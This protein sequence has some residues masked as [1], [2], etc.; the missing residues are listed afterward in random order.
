MKTKTIQASINLNSTVPLAEALGKVSLPLS[1]EI[2][3]ADRSRGDNVGA[4]RE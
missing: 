2:V 3:G 4:V 1:L